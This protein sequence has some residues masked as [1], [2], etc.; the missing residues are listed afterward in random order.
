MGTGWAV[1]RIAESGRCWSRRGNGRLQ[2]L[3][4]LEVERPAV[5]PPAVYGRAVRGPQ[6]PGSVGALAGQVDREGLV[7][8][9]GAAALPVPQV[10]DRAVRR[11]QVDHEVTDEGVDDVHL[12]RRGHA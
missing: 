11:D 12:H 8:V 3:S 10:V 5:D 1:W 9:V 4:Q 6:R 2:P 7:D